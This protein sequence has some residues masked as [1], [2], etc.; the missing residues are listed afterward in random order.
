MRWRY[1]GSS[2]KETAA[3]S[4]SSRRQVL[5]FIQAFNLAGLDGLMAGRSSGR[6]RTTPSEYIICQAYYL[7]TLPNLAPFSKRH[8]P[9]NT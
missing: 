4:A 8:E 5:L 6:R 7:L 1:E 9:A 2:R 3:F